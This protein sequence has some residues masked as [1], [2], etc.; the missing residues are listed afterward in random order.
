MVDL[1]MRLRR[2]ND[3]GPGAMPG[4]AAV[5]VGAT[6]NAPCDPSSEAVQ[7]LSTTASDRSERRA[8]SAPR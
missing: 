5:S 6:P 8:A 3:A 2:G 4:P 7:A 1:G